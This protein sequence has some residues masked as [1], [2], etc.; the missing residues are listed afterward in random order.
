MAF[1][2]CTHAHSHVISQ[3]AFVSKSQ[4]S[5]WV[6]WPPPCTKTNSASANPLTSIGLK[7]PLAAMTPQLPCDISGLSEKN[8]S[9]IAHEHL[10]LT[11]S[12]QGWHI[13]SL[14][15]V[16]SS[17]AALLIISVRSLFFSICADSTAQIIYRGSKA[18][19]HTHLL[20]HLWF[21]SQFECLTPSSPLQT[22]ST[23]TFKYR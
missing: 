6:S 7:G 11:M 12:A 19:I 5:V 17:A 3:W 8:P 21:L 13:D 14:P 2:F 20:S 4:K 18:I 1:T 23:I 15:S 16:Q 22:L 9:L 10:S